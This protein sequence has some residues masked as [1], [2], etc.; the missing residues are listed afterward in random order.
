[1]SEKFILPLRSKIA[2]GLVT[3]LLVLVVGA[4]SFW[5][6]FRAAE[7]F[8]EV[9]HTSQV[10]LEQRKLLSALVDVETA[11]RGYALTANSAFLT[12]YSAAKT[13]VP[14]SIGRLRALTTDHP[15]QQTR[16]DTLESVANDQLA[17]N[18]QIINLRNTAGFELTSKLIG[19][20]QAKKVM[21][22]ARALT[23]S[24]EN[25]ENRILTVR[26]ANQKRDERLAFLVIGIGG[27]IA[28]LLSLL[29]NRA[30][31]NDVIERERQ[32][33]MIENQTRQLTKQAE[34]LT[35]QQVEQDAA[36]YFAGYDRRHT[37]LVSPTENKD[38]EHDGVAG[39][40][41][42]E[43][44]RL[45]RGH[46]MIAPSGGKEKG[47][48]R[49]PQQ[50]KSQPRRYLPHPRTAFRSVRLSEVQLVKNALKIAPRQ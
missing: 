46:G 1:M 24:M 26:A 13:A 12:P 30:I 8:E 39:P 16:L 2:A 32:R 38:G 36:A 18:D 47:S 27:G 44:A 35:A 20:E 42:F 21:D 48:S 6:L 5:M 40:K 41:G 31:R 23:A 19:T 50:W 34:T 7:S 33:E 14:V 28:F 15:Q 49:C 45:Q 22:H 25:E 11:A 10:L 4:M 9:T 17:L 29:I 3:A 37:A 43:A